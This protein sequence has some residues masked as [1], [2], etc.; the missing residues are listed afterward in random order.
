MF[1]FLKSFQKLNFVPWPNGSG[2]KSHEKSGQSWP[3]GSEDR[4]ENRM[5]NQASGRTCVGGKIIIGDDHW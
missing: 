3:D 2:G 1:D 5:K 4:V